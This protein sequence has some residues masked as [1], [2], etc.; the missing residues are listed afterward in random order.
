MI[1]EHDCW[2]GSLD[3]PPDMAGRLPGH[4]VVTFK[5]RSVYAGPRMVD[6]ALSQVF[7]RVD[8]ALT[9]HAFCRKEVARAAT[10]THRLAE[11]LMSVA[12][13][14]NKIGPNGCDNT[15]GA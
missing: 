2:A 13:R 10:T 5:G 9:V 7:E 8:H 3:M 6:Q 14:R 12:E 1:E 11:H 4:V 15:R